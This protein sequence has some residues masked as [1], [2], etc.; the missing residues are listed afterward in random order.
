M[1]HV[2]VL[3]LSTR[4]IGDKRVTLPIPKSTKEGVLF[5]KDLIEAGRTGR[6]STGRYTLEA[7]VEATTYVESGQDRKCRP[8][9]QPRR[10]GLGQSVTSTIATGRA[11]ALSPWRRPNPRVIAA[12]VVGGLADSDGDHWSDLDLTFAVADPVPVTE[13]LGDWDPGVRSRVR[14]GPLVRP[15]CWIRDLPRVPASRLPAGRP[16]VR[17]GG[18]VRGAR[19]KRFRLLFGD[20]VDLPRPQPPSANDLF[21][22]GVHHAVR[23]R[24]SIERGRWW[25]AE[26]WTSGVRGQAL[27]LACRRR[28]LDGRYGRGFDELPPEVLEPLDAALV[29]S[30]E[31]EEL[32]GALGSAVSGLLRE[33]AEAARRRCSV[34]KQRHKRADCAGSFPMAG[35]RR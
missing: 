13:V 15:F 32:R 17:A 23:A 1:W 25:Q 20:A 35:G 19:S 4:R 11:T 18:R 3:A 28:G 29:R 24:F 6:S 34:G 33:S 21:G 30:L 31:P 10:R 2:P 27:E 26:Y 5:L 14:R 7:V 12:A 9:S 8:D 22:L 16:V